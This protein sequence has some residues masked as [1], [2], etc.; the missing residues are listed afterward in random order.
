MPTHQEITDSLLS[1][2]KRRPGIFGKWLPL[3]Y[4][5]NNMETLDN[6]KIKRALERT[7]NYMTKIPD[8][9][10]GFLHLEIT[11]KRLPAPLGIKWFIC[12]SSEKNPDLC[13]LGNYDKF[14][15]GKMLQANWDRH[16]SAAVAED[17][18]KEETDVLEPSEST[19]QA[20]S[21]TQPTELDTPTTR[22]VTPSV[23]SLQ[24]KDEHD[25]LQELFRSV[26]R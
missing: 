7:G 17:E 12:C 24:L 21:P 26:M 15:F 5:I 20:Q 4:W 11:Q 25:D 10:H 22:I 16:T 8:N 6:G 23:A 13:T 14:L 2:L 9:N 1:H 19:A 3:I 18:E